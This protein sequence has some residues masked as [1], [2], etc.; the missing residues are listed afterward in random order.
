[1][2][3]HE[4]L[5]PRFTCL[6]LLQDVSYIKHKRLCAACSNIQSGVVGNS[7]FTLS[8]MAGSSTKSSFLRPTSNFCNSET[9]PCPTRF[10]TFH[11][12]QLLSYKMVPTMW[13]PVQEKQKELGVDCRHLSLDVSPGTSCWV[14]SRVD[15]L[16]K[17]ENHR[18]SPRIC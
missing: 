18:A 4:E 6:K 5:P 17:T 8:S 1:M 10:P 12:G 16:P 7:S 14:M 15:T 3:D 9:S 2:T 13:S 11:V